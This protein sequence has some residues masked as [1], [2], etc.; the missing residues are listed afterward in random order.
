MKRFA[1]IIEILETAVHGDTIA[2]HGNFWRGK[3]KQEFIALK[4]F[5]QQLIVPGQAANSAIIK[6]TRG[7]A[8]FGTDVTPRPPGA[9]FRRMPAGRPPMPD[10]SIAF[11][12]QWIN[13][14]CP[15]DEVDAPAVPALTAAAPNVDAFIRFFREF[16]NFFAFNASNETNTDIGAYFSAAFTWPG[17][18]NPPDATAWTNAIG[19]S[20]VG[21]AISYLS[22]HQLTI[23]HSHFGTPLDQTAVAEALWQFGRGQLPPD[24]LRP[25]D[26]QHRMNGADMWMVWLAFADAC[27]RRDIQA[28]DWTAL[29]KSICLGLVG[30]ALFRTDRPATERLK[31]TRYRA[32]DPD[33]RQKVVGDFASLSGDKLLDAMIDLGREASF[34]APSA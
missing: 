29:A 19:S 12:E 13:D 14:G 25:Q 17:I 5:G 18:A 30:D 3:S 6:A 34:G 26:P 4:I 2:A 22:T 10:D 7:L 20:P 16:D 31:I 33:V 27:M 28:T 23:I 15:D 32:N 24:P 11:I 1:R 21:D 8:P 9:I